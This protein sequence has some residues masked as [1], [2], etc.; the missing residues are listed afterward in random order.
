MVQQRKKVIA[1]KVSTK[2]MWAILVCITVCCVTMA[3][4]VTVHDVCDSND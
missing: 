3:T 2:D 1:G 4:Y